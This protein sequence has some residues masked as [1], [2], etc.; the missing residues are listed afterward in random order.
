[1]PSMRKAM[2]R[3]K[4]RRKKATVDLRV[5]R[6]RMKVKMNQPWILS[7]QCSFR[8]H[9]IITYHQVET[10]AIKESLC[11]LA[12]DD[13]LL[14]LESAGGEDDGKGDPETTI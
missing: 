9:F 3:V 13:A 1:M 11:A 8:G 5:Q 6:T 14:N 10:K 7:A 4:N 12:S 2:S